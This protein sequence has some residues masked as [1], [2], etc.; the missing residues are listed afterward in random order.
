MMLSMLPKDAPTS[1]VK[2]VAKK[3]TLTTVISFFVVLLTGDMMLKLFGISIH[4]LKVM[5]GVVLIFMA[6]KMV[7]GTLDSKN[8]TKKEAEEVKTSD[9]IAVIPLGIPISFGPGLFAAVIVFKAQAEGAVGLFVLIL[10]FLIN[11][12][13]LYLTFRYSL[14]I[15]NRLGVTGQKIID[16]LMGLIVGAIAVEFMVGGVKAMIGL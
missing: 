8:Q 12:V 11:A 2:I 6:I 1:E 13:V 3:A 15:K 10:A 7:D 5:G 9:D 4:S 16:R 14:I